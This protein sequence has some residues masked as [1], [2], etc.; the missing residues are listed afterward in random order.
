MIWSGN[1]AIVV[2]D[3]DADGCVSAAILLYLLR[4]KTLAYECSVEEVQLFPANS[5]E[6]IWV[7]EEHKGCPCLVAFLDIPFTG[8]MRELLKVISRRCASTKV[9][10]VDHHPITLERLEELKSLVSD[11]MVSRSEPTVKLLVSF[12]EK[13]GKRIPH[14]LLKYAEAVRLMELGLKPPEHLSNIVKL[15][16][17]ISRALKLERNRELWEKM[18]LWMSNPLPIPLSKSELEVLRRVEE[19]LKRRDKELEDAAISL[20]ISAE[21]LGCFRFVDARRKWKRRGATSLATRLSRILKAPT[22]LLVRLGHLEVL[23]IRARNAAAKSI[24]EELI[25]EGLALDVG[26][27][28]NLAVVRLKRDYD[29]SRIKQI[30]L[31]ACRKLL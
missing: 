17:S 12:A 13:K 2:A 29:L 18:A 26:G 24:G 20:A 28:P 15:V 5:R 22:A 31:Q 30:L 27:H 1:E 10:Y 3:W 11:A 8:E 16:A 21:K 19:E 23:V 7:F 9:L 4:S 25:R 14:K 6:T